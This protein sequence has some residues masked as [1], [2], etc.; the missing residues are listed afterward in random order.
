M[1]ETKTS[2]SKVENKSSQQKNK[3]DNFFKRIGKGIKDIF[4]ELKKVAWPDFKTVVKNT[5]IVLGIVG[6]FLVLIT[7]MD[8]GLGVLLELVTGIG[9]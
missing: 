3:K 4:A 9:A 5:G 7:V 6:I 1:K 2:N 8:Y